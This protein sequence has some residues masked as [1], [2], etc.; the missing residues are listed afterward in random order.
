MS[1]LAIVKYIF[2]PLAG[3]SDLSTIYNNV[4]YNKCNRARNSRA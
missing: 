4:H 2:I 1:K 3:N